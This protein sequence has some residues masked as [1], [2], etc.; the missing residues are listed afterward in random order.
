MQ[1]PVQL[2]HTYTGRIQQAVDRIFGGRDAQGIGFKEAQSILFST[3]RFPW[4]LL[5]VHTLI[6]CLSC[7]EGT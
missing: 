7:F 3:L 2:K 6:L 1:T 4:E 5:R